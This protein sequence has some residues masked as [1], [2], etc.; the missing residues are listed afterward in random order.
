MLTCIT[1]CN[2]WKLKNEFRELYGKIRKPDFMAHLLN[3]LK[4]R[5]RLQILSMISRGRHSISELQQ[6]LKKRG[7]FHSQ[8]TIVKEYL[9]PLMNVGLANESQN[10]YYAT[11]FGCRLNEIA[12]DLQ[13]IGDILPPHSEC[14]EET[15]I[16]AISDEPRTYECLNGIIP[17]KNT[18]RVLR[19]L[20]TAGLVETAKEREYVFFFRTQ[21]D[22][23][24]ERLS[25]TEKRLYE[26]IP[27]NGDSARRLA[28]KTKISLRRMYKYLR[29]LKG[30]K[31]IFAR[32]RPKSYALTTEGL[33]I[34]STFQRIRNL[35]IEVLAA[36]MQVVKNEET[37]KPLTQSIIQ[38]KHEKKRK[39]IM[40]LT[41]MS[42]AEYY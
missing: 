16:T 21:R 12:K 37:D 40:P 3:A 35:V 5:R 13:E 28:Q 7:Y 17:T 6:E 32:E 19:R 8:K 24:K 30:K 38:T 42:L 29:R 11:S 1:D 22:L 9:T 18:A 2:V 10:K 15:T 27:D 20:Q 41:T 26:N 39:T 34:A 36:A 23:N 4:N 33:R 31:M 25:P 14:Y